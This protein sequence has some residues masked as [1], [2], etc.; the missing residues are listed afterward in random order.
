M[1]VK[2]AMLVYNPGTDEAAVLP[3][4]DYDHLSR[5]YRYSNLAC[6]SDFKAL[7]KTES[8]LLMFVE[9]YEAIVRDGV[10]P[11]AIHNAML[12]IDEYRKWIAFDMQRPFHEDKM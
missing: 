3:W 4:P 9:A 6:C 8:E 11:K 12:A 7:K 1:K 10:D 5:G 2:E